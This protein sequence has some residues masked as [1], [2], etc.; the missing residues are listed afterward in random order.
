MCHI[1]QT[2]FGIQSSFGKSEAPEGRFPMT[3]QPSDWRRLAEQFQNEADPNRLME[4][5]V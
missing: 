3:P 5:A 1:A 2:H 4:L